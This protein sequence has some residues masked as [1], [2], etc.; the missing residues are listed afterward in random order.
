MNTQET[1]EHA[2]KFESSAMATIQSKFLMKTKDGGTIE[3]KELR[4]IPPKDFTSFTKQQQIKSR[5]GTFS[6]VI[7]GRIVR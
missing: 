2:K 4:V 5:H 7:T 3:V 1:L 6:G